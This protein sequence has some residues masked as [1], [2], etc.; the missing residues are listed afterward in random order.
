MY[1]YRVHQ[2]LF[3]VIKEQFLL[4]KKFHYDPSALLMGRNACKQPVAELAPQCNPCNR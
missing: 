2:A 3:I 1:W 4:L